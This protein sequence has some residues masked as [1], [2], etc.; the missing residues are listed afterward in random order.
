MVSRIDIRY[1]RNDID[2]FARSTAC[3]AT[4]PVRLQKSLDKR[5]KSLFRA[6]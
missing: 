4:E 5:L 3:L 6:E 2:D 1:R